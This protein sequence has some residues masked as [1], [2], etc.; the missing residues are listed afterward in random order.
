MKRFFVVFILI[1]TLTSCSAKSSV[2]PQLK[3]IS[4][5][6]E[7]SYYNEVY[8]CDCVM[9]KEGELTAVIKLPETLEGFTLK[10][11]SESVTAEYLGISYTPTDGNMPFSS[12]LE[13][14][15]K[16][17]CLSESVGKAKKTDGVYKITA[18]EGADKA[19]LYLTEAGLPIKLE[20][21]DER[22][23]AEFYNVT[24]QK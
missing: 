2:E 19:S 22:F 6:A 16:K 21:P 17:L 13:E 11:N 5:V 12:V 3:N 15:Y 18:G 10:V 1:F 7:I 9:S 14:F 24:I 8:S 4:F 23:F 20:M